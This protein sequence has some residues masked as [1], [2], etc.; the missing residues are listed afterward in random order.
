MGEIKTIN[1]LLEKMWVDY[2]EMNPQ[3]QKI[4]NLFESRGDKVMNDHIAMR[5]FNHPK[6]NVD[7][8]SQAF[9]KSGYEE[10]G[11]YQFEEK[12]LFAKHF[13][14]PDKNMPKV[15]ISE[16]KLEEF[17]DEFQKEVSDLIEQIP[18]NFME[19]FDVCS[20]GRP[21]DV[22]FE[23]YE[24]L[25]KESDY[26]A[27]LSA[28]G[29]RP[30]HFTVSLNHLSS[31]K[32]LREL[33]QVVKE[34]GYSLNESGGEIKGSPEVL[35]E[36]SSTLADKV[37]VQFSDGEKIVPSCYYEFAHRYP[38]ENGELYEGFVAKSADKILRVRRRVKRI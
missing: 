29:F 36:Q 24:K 8:L 27:W 19:R 10:K 6:V 34:A 13:Q 9:L 30:N 12:K 33:N 4:Y 28:I 23:T 7:V 11:E 16:L 38:M 35:L 20:A 2:T 22:S 15:F 5:T 3:A 1:H 37:S 17:S 32:N 18:E 26:G 31:L 21:W 14:H 25:K